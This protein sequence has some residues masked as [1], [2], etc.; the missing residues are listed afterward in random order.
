MSVGF[1]VMLFLLVVA[2]LVMSWCWAIVTELLPRW[3]T[4]TVM[5]L[6]TCLMVWLG[7]DAVNAS[8]CRRYLGKGQ[9]VATYCD[10]NIFAP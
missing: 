5:S 8:E 4:I 9:Y 1:A 6:V 3:V 10:G 7:I 2:G